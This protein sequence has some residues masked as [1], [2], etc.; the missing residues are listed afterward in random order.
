MV[1]WGVKHTRGVALRGYM[2][3]LV[4]TPFASMLVPQFPHQRKAGH[5]GP[6]E[7]MVGISRTPICRRVGGLIQC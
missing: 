6:W 1:R 5:W 2:R 3:S 4:Q 7:R